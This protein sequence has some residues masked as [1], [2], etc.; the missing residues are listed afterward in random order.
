MH[1]LTFTVASVVFETELSNTWQA[2][3]AWIMCVVEWLKPQTQGRVVELVN[4]E[5]ALARIRNGRV[6]HG[7][8]VA[9]NGAGAIDHGAE[10]ASNHWNSVIWRSLARHKRRN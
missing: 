2:L 5:R 10:T 1:S 6:T 3:G 7:N 8:W 4:A 9:A